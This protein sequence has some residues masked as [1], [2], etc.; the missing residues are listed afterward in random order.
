MQAVKL[1]VPC[2]LVIVMPLYVIDDCPAG[3]MNPEV[4]T[5]LAG[6]MLCAYS[7][8]PAEPVSNPRGMLTVFVP[9]EVI[10][11]VNRASLLDD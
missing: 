6:K 10:I 7:V 3:K 2:R 4:V 5:M 8:R 1:R 11:T 9:T